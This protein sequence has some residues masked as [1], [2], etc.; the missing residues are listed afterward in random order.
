MSDLASA[1]K[2]AS[3]LSHLAATI[4][5]RAKGGETDKPSYTQ[6]LLKDGPEICAKKLGEEGVETALAIALGKQDDIAAE[7]ADLLYH[8]FV[9][10]RSQGVCLDDVAAA[11]IKRQG[12]SG[13][14]E[15]AGR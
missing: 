14:E 8:L 6:K 9:G 10:L 11:L 15:K 13:I 5:A 1:D 7:S 2:L 4:D 3:A 12:I